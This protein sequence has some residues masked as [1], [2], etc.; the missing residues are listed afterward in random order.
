MMYAVS[1]EAFQLSYDSF[2][3]QFAEYNVFIDYLNTTWMQRKELWSKAWRPH[4]TFNTNNL[5][6]SYHNQLKTNYLGRSRSLRVDRL[7]YLLSQ[8]LSLDYRQENVKAMFGFASIRLT[9]EEEKRKKAFLIPSD[10]AFNMVEKL[11]ECYQCKSFTYDYIYYDIDFQEGYLQNCSC[12]DPSKLCK[13]IFLV[14]RIFE[15]PF[16]LRV[17]L[18]L[19]T[20]IILVIVF[21]S[22]KPPPRT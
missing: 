18:F 17:P 10:D 5:I 7:V 6:E 1:P 20:L 11:G 22:M 3:A 12:D 4:A 16:S 2:L 9:K 19:P 21:Y 14:H 8:V 15:V 13:H